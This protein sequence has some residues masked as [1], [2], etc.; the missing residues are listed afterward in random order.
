MSLSLCPA[1]IYVS[2]FGLELAR[3]ANSVA[4]I[5]FVE[6]SPFKSVGEEWKNF[7]PYGWDVQI[8]GSGY[9]SIDKPRG[10]RMCLTT[11]NVSGGTLTPRPH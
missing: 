4:G 7:V 9:S 3:H 6:G 10:L 2:H 1:G 11:I 8:N 5:D